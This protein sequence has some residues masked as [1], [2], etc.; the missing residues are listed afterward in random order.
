M[1]YQKDIY[2]IFW[3]WAQTT[4]P[5]KNIS[6]IRE[7][8]FTRSTMNSCWS[9]LSQIACGVTLRL[10]E[11]EPIMVATCFKGRHFQQ[12]MILQ[13]VRWYLTYTP[14]VTGTSKNWCKHV[15][16]LLTTAPL[17]AGSFITPH[18]WKRLFGLKRSA[19]ALGGEW[20]K[21]ISKWKGR[22]ISSV[23]I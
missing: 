16:S 13:S 7:E 18:N 11:G 22:H 14:S 17:I 20:M 10:F 15:A 2:F 8:F 21:R 5:T 1:H 4:M 3:L 12:D 23:F 19:L 6:E 9:V